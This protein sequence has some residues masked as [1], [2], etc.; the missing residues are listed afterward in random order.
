MMVKGQ[1]D[2]IRDMQLGRL[3]AAVCM[4]CRLGH[5]VQIIN[6]QIVFELHCNNALNDLTKKRKVVD[7]KVVFQYFMV[8]IRLF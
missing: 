4:V 8:K 1:V 6:G 3:G 2:V 7:G 5:S